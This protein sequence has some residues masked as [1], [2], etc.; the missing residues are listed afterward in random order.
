MMSHYYCCSCE[1]KS[2]NSNEFPIVN[3]LTK[4]MT[5]PCCKSTNVVIEDLDEF[6]EREESDE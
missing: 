5:C 6:P 2:I 4:I 1:Y 3:N